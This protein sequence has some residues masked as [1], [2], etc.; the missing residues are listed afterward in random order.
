MTGI[1]YFFNQKVLAFASFS[2]QHASIVK[3]FNVQYSA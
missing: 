3:K 1:F 2:L